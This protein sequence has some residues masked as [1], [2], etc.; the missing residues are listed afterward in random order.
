MVLARQKGTQYGTR[1]STEFVSS[2]LSDGFFSGE[3]YSF[4][5]GIF[6]QFDRSKIVPKVVLE[7][8]T[9]N[10]TSTKIFIT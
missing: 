4:Q 10:N 1:D 6:G 9:E 5:A 8:H 2:C 7:N 3:W